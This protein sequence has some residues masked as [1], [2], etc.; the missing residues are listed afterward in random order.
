[1]I[2]KYTNEDFQYHWGFVNWKDKIILDIGADYGSTAE[3]FIASGAKLIYASEGDNELYN[4]LVENVRHMPLIIPIKSW[5]SGPNDFTQLFINFKVDIAKIDCEGAEI[6]L[7][8]V[9]DYILKSIKEYAIE[10]H[11]DDIL[12]RIIE[13]FTSIGFNISEIR[14]LNDKISVVYFICLI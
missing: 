3:C 6:H 13:R 2:I 9:S 12:N 1:M 14:Y 11:S 10:C 5:I 4:Q 8:E 7:L